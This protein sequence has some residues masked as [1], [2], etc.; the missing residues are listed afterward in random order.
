MNG[1]KRYNRFDYNSIN[2]SEFTGCSLRYVI[3][4]MYFLGRK[5]NF[6]G[7]KF[8]FLKIWKWDIYEYLK[9]DFKDKILCLKN[10]RTLGAWNRQFSSKG[11]GISCI[12]VI[13]GICEAI[14]RGRDLFF[15]VEPHI[16]IY[17]MYI[18]YIFLIWT[19]WSLPQD[20]QL[21]NRR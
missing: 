4:Y 11:E 17:F 12:Y 10:H 7:L 18:K 16:S 2:Q 14:F 21:Q 9:K 1:T 15:C 5:N 3:K 20:V 6:S 13:L 19:T 8:Y